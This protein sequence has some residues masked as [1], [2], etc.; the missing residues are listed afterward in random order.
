MKVYIKKLSNSILNKYIGSKGLSAYI[1]FRELNRSIFSP[2]NKILITT[3]SLGSP[4]LS[5][6]KFCV[7]TKSPATSSW[8]N[9]YASRTW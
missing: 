2:K 5:A 9:S 8:T 6:V 7:A 3:E 1:L 4:I